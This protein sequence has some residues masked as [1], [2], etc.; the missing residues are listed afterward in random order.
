MNDLCYAM[1]RSDLMKKTL[2][3][4][5]LMFLIFIVSA[6]DA[7]TRD[8]YASVGETRSNGQLSFTLDEVYIGS[9]SLGTLDEGEV[10]I[11]LDITL[12]NIGT[13]ITRTINPIDDFLLS[14]GTNYILDTSI[15][16]NLSLEGRVEVGERKSGTLVF[17]VDEDF[18][19][20]IFTF[21][22]EMQAEGIFIY[23]I[24]KND[25]SS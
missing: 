24:T 3:L 18:D 2:L 19:T 23:E 9:E 25:L 13:V 12:Q 5:G 22:T 15:E 11:V 21:E 7:F 8:D 14:N 16:G 10:F 1:G 20:L 17:R 4:T 6:C